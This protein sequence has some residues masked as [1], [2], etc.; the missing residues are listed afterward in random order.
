MICTVVCRCFG[1]KF[2]ISITVTF[3]FATT[4]FTFDEL[5]CVWF[6]L[7]FQSLS[8]CES[9]HGP[10]TCQLQLFILN[11]SERLRLSPE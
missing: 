6:K 5:L 7:H 2:M 3:Y 11:L 1:A 8:K 4:G 10:L 9:F